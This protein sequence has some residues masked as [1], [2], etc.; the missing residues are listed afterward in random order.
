MIV[1]VVTDGTPS[2]LSHLKVSPGPNCSGRDDAADPT[3]TSE[4]VSLTE[5]VLNNFSQQRDAWKHSL[6]YLSRTHNE[7]V[8]MYCMT[9][10]EVRAPVIAHCHVFFGRAAERGAALW[11]QV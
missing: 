11:S 6:F 10:L 3:L 9:V 5:E 1:I 7:Y 8:M 4:L 2:R